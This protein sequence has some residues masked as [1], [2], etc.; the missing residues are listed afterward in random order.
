[1]SKPSNRYFVYMLANNGK[2]LYTGVTSDLYRRLWQHR[3]N[4]GS[5]HTY[6]YRIHDLVWFEETDDITAAIA[7][8]KQVKMWRR[9][10]KMNLVEFENPMWLDMAR[11]WYE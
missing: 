10:W 1:M 11:G 8:E 7:R 3:N 2:M 4:R 6:R 9:Q 5:E